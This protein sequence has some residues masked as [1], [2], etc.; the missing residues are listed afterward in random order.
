MET[1]RCVAVASGMAEGGQ[2]EWVRIERIGDK[3]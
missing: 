1:A 3:E 2:T